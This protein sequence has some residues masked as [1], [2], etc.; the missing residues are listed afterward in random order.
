MNYR[1][2]RRAEYRTRRLLEG[3]GFMCVRSAGSKGAVD[4]VAFDRVSLKFLQVKAGRGRLTPAERATFELLPV[5]V[6]VT[7]EVWFWRPR[8]SAPTIERL[9]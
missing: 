3:A 7:K 5:P 2:G 8:A 6:N 9:G 4:L 1:K